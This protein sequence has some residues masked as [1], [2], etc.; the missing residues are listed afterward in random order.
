MKNNLIIKLAFIFFTIDMLTVTKICKAEPYKPDK[1]CIHL[2]MQKEET[3][4]ANL[5]LA[6]QKNNIH[7]EQPEKV[8]HAYQNEETPEASFRQSYW[9]R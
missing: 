6:E 8:Q 5:Q 7:Q 9:R 4:K 2:L 3:T 1:H